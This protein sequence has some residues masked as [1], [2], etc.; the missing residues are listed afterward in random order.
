MNKAKKTI[1]SSTDGWNFQFR[2]KNTTLNKNPSKKEEI[3]AQLHAFFTYLVVFSCILVRLLQVLTVTSVCKYILVATSATQWFLQRYLIVA[4]VAT[5][6]TE[7]GYKVAANSSYV[8]PPALF[9]FITL[10]I[11]YFKVGDRYQV[12][13]VANFKFICNCRPLGPLALGLSIRCKITFILA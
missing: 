9:E 7:H 13:C 11:F 6:N 2:L 3:R 10:R 1:Q 8:L 12:F 5:R 4:T